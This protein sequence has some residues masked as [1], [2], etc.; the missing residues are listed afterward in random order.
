MLTGEEPPSL[1]PGRTS[2][3]QGNPTSA[4][5][6]PIAIVGMGCRLPGNANKETLRVTLA[7]SDEPLAIIGMELRFPTASLGA[8]SLGAAEAVAN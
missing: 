5:S 7:P 6:E 8:A 1:P 2:L 3:P 4:F